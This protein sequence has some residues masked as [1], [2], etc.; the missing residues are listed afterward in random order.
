METLPQE[1]VRKILEHVSQTAASPADL[2][3]AACVST[4]FHATAYDQDVLKNAGAATMMVKKVHSFP[5]S[6]H[7]LDRIRLTGSV[8]ALYMMGMVRFYVCME[9]GIG[10]EML[11]KAAGK[12]HAPALYQCAVT[13]INGSGGTKLD[14]CDEGANELLYRATALGYRPAAFELAMRIKMRLKKGGVA[15]KRGRAIVRIARGG[16]FGRLTSILAKVVRRKSYPFSSSFLPAALIVDQ[17][18]KS[19]P[20]AAASPA[21]Q[22]SW[23]A[24]ARAAH[25]T[26]Q[27]NPV[28][29]YGCYNPACG[30]SA[31]GRTEFRTC[32]DCDVAQY[33][34]MYCWAEDRDRHRS[35]RHNG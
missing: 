2:C 3:G 9:Y 34:S 29:A 24:L 35:D 30:R 26:L 33:C 20:K 15:K 11:A 7:F 10:G 27:N 12:D 23:G 6:L 28:G 14:A 1:L 18:R 21:Q 8:D 17:S 19:T 4:L 13:L 5:Q 32:S 31:P 25:K 22:D 16:N